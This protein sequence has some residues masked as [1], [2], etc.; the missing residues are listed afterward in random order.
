MGREAAAAG[1]TGI[2]TFDIET[3]R[4]VGAQPYEVLAKAVVRQ[5]GRA[6]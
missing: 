1:V 3:E 4:V 6:R 2:P 5:G